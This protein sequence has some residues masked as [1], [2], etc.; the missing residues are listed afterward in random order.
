M[1]YDP[2][3]RTITIDPGSEFVADS[4]VHFVHVHGDI[5][6]KANAPEAIKRDWEIIE[7][8]LGCSGRDLSADDDERIRLA[9]MGYYA[10][11]LAPSFELQPAFDLFA[12]SHDVKTFR[13]HKPPT[14]VM[15]VF[16]RMLAK[17]ENI[18]KKRAHDIE[19]EKEKMQTAMSALG[20]G[21]KAPTPTERNSPDFMRKSEQL[22]RLI[23]GIFAVCWFAW[24]YNET[25]G[26]KEVQPV[27][28]LIILSVPA[29]VFFALPHL[30]SFLAHAAR[31]VRFVFS[32]NVMWI[33]V[34][35]AWGYVFDWQNRFDADRYA[36]LFILPVIGSWVGLWLWKWSKSQ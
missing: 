2:K 22:R 36:A 16:D 9:W 27:G 6:R 13:Q 7:D 3:S 31:D 24:F 21:A 32:A 19:Q 8:W 34:I 20:R 30:L 11:G 26:F 35:A 5:A 29:A 1:G 14:A 12:T 23:F 25:S 28:W 15:D 18:A 33:F 4:G 10:V 17:D